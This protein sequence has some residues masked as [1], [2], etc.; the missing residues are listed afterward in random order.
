MIPR[1][2]FGRSGHA[3]SRIIFGLYALSHASQAEADRVL[4]ILLAHGV[5]HIDTAALYDEAEKRI[6]AWMEK[7]RADFFIATKTRSRDYEGAWK[8]LQRS[9]ERLRIDQIDL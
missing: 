4:E 5:N 3:S 7:H 9:L 1:T 8:N 2:V 6:G